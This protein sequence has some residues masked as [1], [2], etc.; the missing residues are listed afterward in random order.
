MKRTHKNNFKKGKIDKEYE[1][2]QITN[3]IK[4]EEDEFEEEE[5]DDDDDDDSQSSETNFIL[6][7]PLYAEA[8]KFST[9]IPKKIPPEEQNKMEKGTTLKEKTPEATPLKYQT[10]KHIYEK[11][12]MDPLEQNP[13]KTNSNGAM[14]ILTFG[15]ESNTPAE[16]SI[17]KSRKNMK[18][19]NF[20]CDETPTNDTTIVRSSKLELRST[21]IYEV[22]QIV[23]KEIYLG[24]RIYTSKSK[25]FIEGSYNG[26]ELNK[27]QEYEILGLDYFLE[28]YIILV[29]KN[30]YEEVMGRND[31]ESCELKRI[32]NGIRNGWIDTSLENS[33]HKTIIALDY[34]QFQQA[35][36]RIFIIEFEKRRLQP[37]VEPIEIKNKI[38]EIAII[39]KPDSDAI[40]EPKMN[41]EE[42]KIY[43]IVYRDG[44]KKYERKGKYIML[45]NYRNEKYKI[46][47]F[48]IV[49]E[50]CTNNELN[51]EL[52]ISRNDAIGEMNYCEIAEINENDKDDEPEMCILC[53]QMIFEFEYIYD[54]ELSYHDSCIHYAYCRH[55]HSKQNIHY[56][57]AAGRFYC[58]E[59]FS[60]AKKSKGYKK[61]EKQYNKMKRE[62]EKEKEEKKRMEEE[63]EN[64][65]ETKPLKEKKETEKKMEEEQ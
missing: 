28:K 15:N 50:K 65:C 51:I 62:M 22:M 33:D 59:C 10:E 32:Y 55:C 3:S 43:S 17:S 4:K 64:K 24:N 35:F 8:K 44:K 20:K 26:S 25:E 53:R 29:N 7:F 34:F 31:E 13:N 45:T 11:M 39:L 61:M 1:T 60:I 21:S 23:A 14:K 30:Y 57:L 41:G 5:E 27:D 40:I 37:N 6:K 63:R 49:R 52:S 56:S 16:T 42:I 36:D 9:R 48:I 58:D 19:F 47:N 2:I 38:I 18:S 12:E 46:F 54:G